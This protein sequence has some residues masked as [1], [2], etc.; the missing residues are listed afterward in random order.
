[1]FNGINLGFS[2]SDVIDR[3]IVIELTDIDKDNRK[4]EESII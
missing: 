4:T 3:A 1:M 2:E